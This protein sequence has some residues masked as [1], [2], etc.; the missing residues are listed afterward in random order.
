[1]LKKLEEELSERQKADAKT[2]SALS[3][4]EDD[5]KSEKK[6]LEQL[7]KQHGKVSGYFLVNQVLQFVAIHCKSV[8]HDT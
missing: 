4:K 3:H 2:Q 5:I 6:K 1:M 7:E 8:F